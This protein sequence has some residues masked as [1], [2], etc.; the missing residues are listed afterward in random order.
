[1]VTTTT[2]MWI[3]AK[4]NMTTRAIGTAKMEN[5]SSVGLI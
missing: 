5:K 4:I 3:E 2:T 1:M